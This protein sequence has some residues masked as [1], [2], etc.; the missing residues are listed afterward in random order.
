MLPEEVLAK[1]RKERFGDELDRQLHDSDFLNV[2]LWSSF[3]M[4]TGYSA[5]SGRVSVWFVLLALIALHGSHYLHL[6]YSAMRVTRRKEKD[7]I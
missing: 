2:S 7:L 5:G 1:T 4:F 6:R 3:Y